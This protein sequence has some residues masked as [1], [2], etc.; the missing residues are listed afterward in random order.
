MA[1]IDAPW[2]QQV[3]VPLHWTWPFA[4]GVCACAALQAGAVSATLGVLRHVLPTN[5]YVFLAVFVSLVKIAVRLISIRLRA[6]AASLAR[7]ALAPA[8]Q[9]TPLAPAPTPADQAPN[10]ADVPVRSMRR[11]RVLPAQ[12][13]TSEFITPTKID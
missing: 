4:C 5:V 1:Y 8:T 11:P 6:A 3:G 9:P 10:E 13:L 7:V 2:V 12:N